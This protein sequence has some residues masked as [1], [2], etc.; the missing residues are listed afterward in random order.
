MEIF[1]GKFT[2]FILVALKILIAIVLFTSRGII[3]AIIK[4]FNFTIARVFFIF[5]IVIFLLYKIIKSNI[6]IKM[7]IIFILLCSF[8]LRA[9]WLLNV[10]SVP[11]S[12]FSVIYESGEK[13]LNGDTSMFWGTSYIARFPH[14]TIMVLYMA[15]MIKLFP[16]HNLLMMKMVNLSLGTLCVFLIYLIVK[17]I[18]NSEKKAL[19]AAA[20]ASLFP[21][22]ITYTAVFCTENIA[23]PFYLLSIYMLL[24][25][26]KKKNSRYFLILSGVLL[27]FGNLFRMVAI[28]MIIAYGMYL[29]IYSDD[30][31][32][33]KIQNLL[34]Y[35]V[36]YFLVMFVVSGSL[37]YMRI[38]E[39]PLTKG[40]EPKITNILKGTNYE[41]GGKWNSEDAAIPEMY[42]YDYD[43]V[44]EASKKIIVERLT[45]TP[46][47]KLLRFYINK[48]AN[49]WNEGDLSGVFW[50]QLDVPKDDIKF[51]VT[52]SG[53]KVLQLIY[54]CIIL[55]IFIGLFNRKGIDKNKEI[56]LF[57]IIFCGYSLLYL[58]TEAQARYSY[59]ASWVL[60]VLAIEGID[61]ISLKLRKKE[62][63]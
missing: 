30:K 21:P 15:L 24:V 37:Q 27:A 14:L 11:V 25:A 31:L 48:F 22:L 29:L 54:N 6:N 8:A 10:N 34:L 32:I 56:N 43:K 18:F 57:Y 53:R 49:Q 40:S 55:L 41:N 7:Q 19:I 26:M 51:D 13:F 59:I 12:D 2:S 38:T 61:F 47:L 16:I 45:T 17:K 63:M 1:K 4:E 28:I 9:L 23:I 39:Y 44:N 20:F 58:I 50:S 42:N 33:V 46:P 52:P 62:E 36:P 60:I 5:A 3:F 35:L